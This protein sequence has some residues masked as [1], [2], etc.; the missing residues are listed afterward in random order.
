MG[1]VD[2][3]LAGLDEPVRDAF[4]RVVAV[5]LEVVPDAEQGKSYGMAALRHRGK[6]LLG[7]LA[8]RQHLSVFPFSAE[9]VAAVRERLAGY[10]LSRGTIRF[11]LDRLLPDDVARDIVRLR[12]RE[13]SG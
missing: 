5:A 4:G 8:T 3:Y 13:I 7:F 9:V 1:S 2:D 12:A 6:P 11:T 10:D